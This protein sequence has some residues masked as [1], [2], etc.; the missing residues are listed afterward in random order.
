MLR[1]SEVGAECKLERL[2]LVAGLVAYGRR[3][4]HAHQ[5]E[6]RYPDSA[7]PGRVAQLAEIELVLFAVARIPEHVRRE[8]VPV[9]VATADKHVSGIEESRDTHGIRQVLQE[10][11]REDDLRPG[12]EFYITTNRIAKPILRSQAVFLVAA[13]RARAAGI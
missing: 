7:E 11:H 13:H 6:R 4:A 12:A 1:A 3:Y 8:D 10:R 5:P 2:R 9:C